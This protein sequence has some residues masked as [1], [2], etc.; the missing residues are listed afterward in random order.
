LG[1]YFLLIIK[2]IS[3]PVRVPRA[4]ILMPDFTPL[5][6]RAL[7]EIYPGREGIGELDESALARLK[8]TLA[9]PGR[10]FR[11]GPGYRR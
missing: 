2:A 8:E 9:P 1:F 10:S 5:H 6:Y 3:V 11:E 4:S 7:Y